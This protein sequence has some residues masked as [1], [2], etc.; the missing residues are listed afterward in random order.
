MAESLTAA[1]IWKMFAE[2][3]RRMQETD[4]RMQET[5][6]RMQETDRQIQETARVV[7]ETSR[8]I[9]E[10]GNRLGE[11]VESMVRP[12]AVRLFQERGIQVH[13]VHGEVSV[14]RHGMAAEFDLLVVNDTEM[15][16]IECKSKLSTEDVKEH[17]LRLDKVK[18][19]LPKY[20]ALR[21]YGA[22]ATMVAQEEAIH[23]AEKSG[24]FVIRQNG[25][26]VEVINA[27]DFRPREF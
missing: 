7:R 24:L 1:E 16:V 12:A 17:L 6:R 13:E 21:V 25:E 5:D 10:L 18:Q 19:L 20:A 22:V 8:K 4:R 27:P 9:G 2:T 3:D 11:F 14:K 15:V 23:Y 26:S